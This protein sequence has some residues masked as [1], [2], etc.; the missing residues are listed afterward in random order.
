[1]NTRPNLSGKHRQHN[2]LGAIKKVDV[3]TV[4]TAAICSHSAGAGEHKRS[5][6]Q[7]RQRRLHGAQFR[8]RRKRGGDGFNYTEMMIALN[9][10]TA[11]RIGLLA[12]SKTSPGLFDPPPQQ[13][14]HSH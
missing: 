6:C 10:E 4:D 11:A 12:P 13:R 14:S 3:D 2:R 8:R 1:M 9:P 7:H 5:G